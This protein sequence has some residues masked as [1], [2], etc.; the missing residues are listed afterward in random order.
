MKN[1]AIKLSIAANLFLS[2]AVIWLGFLSRPR[3][4]LQSVENGG[5]RTKRPALQVVPRAESVRSTESFRWSRLESTNYHVY[6]ANLRQVGCPERTIRD[7]I[8]AD[9]D[10]I[11]APRREREQL[12]GRSLPAAGAGPGRSA[13]GEDSIAR[14]QRL[15]EEEAALI[16]RVLNPEP[17]PGLVEAEAPGY[18]GQTVSPVA[19]DDPGPA[20]NQYTVPFFMTRPGPGFDFSAEQ[21]E[22]VNEVQQWFQKELGSLDP[23]DPEYLKRWRRAQPV[24]DELMRAWLGVDGFMH[25]QVS[26][27]DDQGNLPDRLSR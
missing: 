16:Q 25:Y 14:L 20:T 13:A 11:Y 10:A 8:A 24:A 23:Q 2:G 4:D 1:C 19:G 27:L 5:E 9:V 17:A 7:I 6:V 15:K 18:P 26:L 12:L 22:A 3:Q 21:I